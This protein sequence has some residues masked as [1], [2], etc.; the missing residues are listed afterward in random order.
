MRLGTC[1]DAIDFA[2]ASDGH[3]GTKTSIA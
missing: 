2:A 1:A 3:G